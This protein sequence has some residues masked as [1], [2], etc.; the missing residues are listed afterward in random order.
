MKV[1]ENASL[2]IQ[3]IQVYKMLKYLYKNKL[4]NRVQHMH[5]SL[6]SPELNVAGLLSQSD[7]D[8]LFKSEQEIFSMLQTYQEIEKK[9]NIYI[10][11]LKRFG[12]M[13]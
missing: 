7:M 12:L 8:H 10:S 2:T 4:Q 13:K 6:F 5:N 9:K 11:M 3:T 1:T